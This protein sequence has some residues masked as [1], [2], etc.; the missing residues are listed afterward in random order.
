V[1]FPLS[2]LFSPRFRDFVLATVRVFVAAASSRDLSSSSLCVE[3]SV[4]RS[5]DAP[6]SFSQVRDQ[7]PSLA[8]L[9]PP[10]SP[11]P[12]RSLSRLGRTL[13]KRINPA[14]PRSALS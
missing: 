9:F 4:E 7:V 10:D 5:E 12:D 14:P 11:R 8:P 2:D 6:P 1:A 3:L 13:R